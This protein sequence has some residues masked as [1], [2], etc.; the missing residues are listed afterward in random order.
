MPIVSVCVVFALEIATL[1]SEMGSLQKADGAFMANNDTKTE[2]VR[3]NDSIFLEVDPALVNSI[4]MLNISVELLRQQ[5]SGQYLDLMQNVQELNTS[6]ADVQTT[7]HLEVNP[8]LENSIQILNISV[9]LLHQ[10]LSGQYLDLMQNVQELMADVQTIHLEVNPALENSIQILNIS[11]E[12]L[13][14]QL[15][16]QYLDLMRNVQELNTSIQMADI[17]RSQG[18]QTVRNMMQHVINKLGTLVQSQ[19]TPLSSCAVLPPSSPSGYYWVMASNGS[20]VQVYCDMTRSCGGVTGGWVRVVELNM[21]DSSQECPSG[22]VQRNDSDILSCVGDRESSGCS[23]LNLA[24]L[25]IRYSQ[26]CGQIEGYQIGSTDAFANDADD[27]D[28]P[29][30]DGVSITHGRN[31]RQHIWTFASAIDEGHV[32]HICP[33]INSRANDPSNHPPAFLGEDYFCDTG[34][35]HRPSGSSSLYGDDP[36]WDGAGCGG[37]STCCSFNNPPWFHKELPQSTADDVEIRI[38]RDQ[39]RGDEDIAIKLM[40]IYIQ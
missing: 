29:Y 2:Q 24:P 23:F 39:H 8:A 40:E 28:A 13:H 35:A 5:L 18:L 15:S 14:Q 36:L 31:P 6:M 37:G 20:A 21:T 16:E 38:C 4:Q 10:Q 9:E 33:C 11:V 22:L 7:D 12:L 30:V 3:V 17:Q 34:I 1:K 32:I 26:V 19:S 27:I 25:N